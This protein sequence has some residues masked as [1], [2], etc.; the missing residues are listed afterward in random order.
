MTESRTKNEAL[1]DVAFLGGGIDSAVGSAHFAAIELDKKFRV[2]AGCFGRTDDINEASGER[3]RITPERIY[4]TPELL[5]AAEKDRIDAVVVLTPTDQHVAHARLFLEQGIPVI[6]EKA[7]TG[8]VAESQELATLVERT[9]GFLSVIFNYTGYPI[10]REIR[11]FIRIGKLGR[12]HQLNLEMPQEGFLRV[13][14]DMKPMN[15]QDWRLR[16]DVEIPVVSLDLGVHLHSIIAFLTGEHPLS[17]VAQSRSKGHFEGVEDN[18]MALIQCTNELDVKMWYG[19]TALGYRNG[20]RVEAFGSRGAI[21]WVQENPEVFTFSDALGNK[22]TYD[23]GCL[24]LSVSRQDRYQRFKAGHP[25][26]FI[27]ALA[28]YYWDIAIA[29]REHQEKGKARFFPEAEVFNADHALE[30]MRLMEAIHASSKNRQW[31]DVT[32]AC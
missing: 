5:L 21:S 4:P 24:E 26:G 11:E 12:I 13:D 17:A 8:T 6:C 18:V 1:F 20:L 2:V 30:G 28:N 25:A 16:S 10:L 23:R 7:L 15:I 29:L 14:K 22:R 31:V 9:S 3:H 19:K 32:P 27:E